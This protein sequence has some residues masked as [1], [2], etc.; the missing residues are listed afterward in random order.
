MLPQVC[1]QQISSTF[2]F[3]QYWNTSDSNT[4][5]MSIVEPNQW[6]QN[7]IQNS[8]GFINGRG[9][10]LCR[11]HPTDAGWVTNTGQIKINPIKDKSFW[12]STKHSVQKR[13]WSENGR[14][15]IKLPIMPIQYILTWKDD[16]LLSHFGVPSFQTDP[17]TIIYHHIPSY[18]IIYHHIPSYTIIYHQIPSYTIIYHHIPSYTIIY[19]H[20]PS[21]TIIYHHIPSYTIIYHHILMVYLN[22][23]RNKPPRTYHSGRPVPTLGGGDTCPKN[24]SMT[25]GLQP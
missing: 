12:D 9:L 14:Y 18:T 7:G 19:H 4:L 13:F 6:K 2:H 5:T 16:S 11:P 25:V 22:C 23:S 20:I 15:L 1:Y 8:S 17:Y 21:Y 24:P 10:H 3:L